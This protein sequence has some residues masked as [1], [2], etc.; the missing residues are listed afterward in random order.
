MRNW[1]LHVC[2]I[3]PLKIEN[4]MNKKNVF[5]DLDFVEWVIPFL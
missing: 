5:K 1:V 4:L 3:W 2:I